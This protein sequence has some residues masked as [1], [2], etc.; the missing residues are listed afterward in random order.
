MKGYIHKD[1]H[2]KN[3]ML[4]ENNNIYIIDFGYLTKIG[5]EI[6]DNM[7]NYKTWFIVIKPCNV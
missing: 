5:S 7:R 4:D 3:I 2:N 1:L 6:T